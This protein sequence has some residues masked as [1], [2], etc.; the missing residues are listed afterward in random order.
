M[1]SKLIFLH[2][3]KTAGSTF[4]SILNDFYP[5]NK[6]FRIN[7]G[8]AIPS[9]FQY[10]AA[11]E[12]YK[13]LDKK[14]VSKV[15]LIMGHM[16]IVLGDEKTEE[17]KFITF[18]RNPINRVI[19][20]YN[21]VISSQENPLHLLVNDLSLGEYVSRHE[22]LQLDNL[23][24]RMISGNMFGQITMKDVDIAKSNIKKHFAFIGFTEYFDKSLILLKKEIGWQK[25][26]IYQSKNISK[27]KNVK[28][29]KDE[30]KIIERY[31]TY[32]IILYNDCL[33]GFLN[34]V[35]SNKTFIQEEL[36]NFQALNA[37]REANFSLMKFNRRKK[38]II[39]KVKKVFNVFRDK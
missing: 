17:F 24:T 8:S 2:V 26:P 21:Y 23:Q 7:G 10:Q 39:S 35:E 18:L 19:S 33:E 28:V 31:N 22:D 1:K 32:D 13:R 14:V 25:Y 36:E 37:K 5:A 29:L 34:R 38:S 15:D 12:N 16:P 11:I 3:P 9:N 4:N 20:D 30:L 6:R 27:N